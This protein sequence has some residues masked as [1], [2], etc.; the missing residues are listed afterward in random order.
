[1]EPRT[2]RFLRIAGCIYGTL[3]AI[4]FG[5]DIVSLYVH[6]DLL[7]V[8]APFRLAW[9][10]GEIVSLLLFLWG[11]LFSIAS[12]LIEKRFGKILMS[13]SLVISLLTGL[14]V[15]WLNWKAGTWL[16]V[17]LISILFFLPYVAI[18]IPT[19]FRNLLE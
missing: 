15:G 14:L 6:N 2:Q 1:M 12:L 8:K 16:G 9:I 13:S 10:A 11:T 18:L 19:H 4:V 7:L 17:L 3:V 5:S